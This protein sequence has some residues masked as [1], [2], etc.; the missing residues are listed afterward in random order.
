M[1]KQITSWKALTLAKG[2]NGKEIKEAMYVCCWD[3]LSAGIEAPWTR[4]ESVPVRP[5]LEECESGGKHGCVGRSRSSAFSIN[6]AQHRP[7]DVP[8][9]LAARRPTQYAQRTAGHQCKKKMY[10]D[11]DVVGGKLRP[12]DCPTLSTSS[13]RG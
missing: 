9:R 12:G 3:I 13:S 2:R 1:A 10:L 6:K 7:I 8:F 5:N 4:I 11:L